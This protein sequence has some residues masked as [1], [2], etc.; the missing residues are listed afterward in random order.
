VRTRRW[1]LSNG[2]ISGLIGVQKGNLFSV[3]GVG[4]HC[5]ILLGWGEVEDQELG[6]RIV[7]VDKSK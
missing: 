2:F 6:F 1:S 4:G 7:G 5:Q 3:L